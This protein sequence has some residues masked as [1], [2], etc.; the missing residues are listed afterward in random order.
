MCFLHV[1]KLYRSRRGQDDVSDGGLQLIDGGSVL[2][3]A[4][5]RLNGFDL[6]VELPGFFFILR[7]AGRVERILFGM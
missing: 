2:M 4:V 5:V 7:V 1:S 6:Y 3:R